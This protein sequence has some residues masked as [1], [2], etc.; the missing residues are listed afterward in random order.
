M[1]VFTSWFGTHTFLVMADPSLSGQSGNAGGMQEITLAVLG[2]AKTGKSTFVQCA[3]DLKKPAVSAASIKKVSLEGATSV[4]RLVELSIDEVGMTINHEIDWPERLGD[5]AISRIDGALLL[6]D[7][8]NQDSIAQV[9]SV[10]G[11]FIKPGS[12]YFF[13]YSNVEE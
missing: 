8:T 3:L 12:S 11:K 2:A 1:S 10:L 13:R 5:Q 9:P 4:L 6:Y 7:V